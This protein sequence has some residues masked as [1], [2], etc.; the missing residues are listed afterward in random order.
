L[1]T[2]APKRALSVVLKNK[3]DAT[4]PEISLV[5]SNSPPAPIHDMI[6]AM[7]RLGARRASLCEDIHGLGKHAAV[8]G[9]HPCRH[10]TNGLCGHAWSPV[11]LHS[12]HPQRHRFDRV[13]VVARRVQLLERDRARRRR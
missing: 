7:L 8:E 3:R 6:R 5:Q 10:A 9:N 2:I 13:T 12:V 1:E 11:P 4:V